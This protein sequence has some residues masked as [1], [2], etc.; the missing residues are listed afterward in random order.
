MK[1]EN[2]SQD[3]RNTEKNEEVVKFE[4]LE[5]KVFPEWMNEMNSYFWKEPWVL[6]S[7]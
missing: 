6:N 4:N 5:A 2:P 3:F 1:W 7:K